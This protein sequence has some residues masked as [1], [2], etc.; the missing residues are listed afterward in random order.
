MTLDKDF[1]KK[2]LTIAV[3]EAVLE[4]LPM[5]DLPARKVMEM[6]SS[7]NQERL[8]T[9]LELMKLAAK[10]PTEFERESNYISFNELLAAIDLWMEKSSAHAE[11]HRGDLERKPAVGFNKKRKSETKKWVDEIV[12][13]LEKSDD[14]D[15]EEFVRM[16]AE[17][18]SESQLGEGATE[19]D[20]IRAIC[21]WF[22]RNGHAELM[23][24]R[25]LLTEKSRT[26]KYYPIID[27]KVARRLG[28]EK[29]KEQ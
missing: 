14:A 20:V 22:V 16:V 15:E 19:D 4:L 5:G 18:V 1:E 26:G 9:S 23:I 27:D 2:F 10:S 28:F 12:A 8:Q 11:K 21:I 3:G 17:A 25:G 29:D 6:M 13:D 7:K 24:E